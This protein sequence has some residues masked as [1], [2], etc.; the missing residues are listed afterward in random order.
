MY[1]GTSKKGC[2][3]QAIGLCQEPQE[4]IPIFKNILRYFANRVKFAVFILD[5]ILQERKEKNFITFSCLE[6]SYLVRAE[7]D[8]NQDP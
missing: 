8:Q 6:L 1:L 4:K 2:H 7:M 5:L 3:S